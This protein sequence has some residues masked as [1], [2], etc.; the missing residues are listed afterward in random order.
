MEDI[1]KERRKLNKIFKGIGDSC[2]NCNL[3]CFTYGWLLPSE[4]ENYDCVVHINNCVSC[5][6]SF[7][8]D[9]KGRRILEKIPRC[10]YYGK[11]KCQ[12][13]K[14]KPFDCVLYPVKVLY[15]PQRKTFLVVLSLD[16][17]YI[18]SLDIS[19]RNNL[20]KKLE[21]Y[22]DEMGS[23]SRREYFELVKQWALIT[24]P[25]KFKYIIIKEYQN[26]R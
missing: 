7:E 12:I 1:L 23:S 16:C 26:N 22:F 15:D 21:Q 19:Q 14:I 18:E 5:L 6:D 17:P 13:H 2:K 10:K 20:L 3:C 4:I 25:K 11:N 8:K 9:R 24:K